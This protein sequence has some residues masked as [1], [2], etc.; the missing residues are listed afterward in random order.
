VRV[1]DLGGEQRSL[2]ELTHP[3]GVSSLAWHPDG[4][5]LATACDDLLIRLWDVATGKV[6]PLE[7]HRNRGIEMAFNPAGDCL[8]SNDWSNML[9]LWDPRTGRQLLQAPSTASVFSRDGSLL[10]ADGS[11]TQV[12]LVRVATHGPLRCLAASRAAVRWNLVGARASPDGRL[13]L[14]SWGDKMVFVD[15][16]S[17]TEM[18]SIDIPLTTALRFDPVG[19][20]LLTTSLLTRER[21]GLLRWP[22]RAEPGA[23]R[24]HVGPPQLLDESV[25][26]LQATGCNADGHVV[27]IPRNNA[28][29]LVLHRPE[30]RRVMLGP[31]EDVRYCAVSPDGV[32]V[33]TGNHWSNQGVGATVW[34]SRSGQVVRDFAVDGACAVGFSPD[35]RWLLTN[36]GGYRLWRVETWEEGP[37]VAP[38]G[39]SGGF[40]FSPD[41]RVLALEAGFSQVRLVAVDSGA[42][43][44][45]LTVPEQTRVG[46]TCFSL[47]GTQ[48]V[49]IGSETRLLY[50]WD[51]RA[52]RAELRELRLDWEW[53]DFPP[54]PP[55]ARGPL[56][57]DVDG[58]SL[59]PQKAP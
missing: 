7:G 20:E 35:G 1:V 23:V 50:I 53:P 40:A 38:P 27:A 58:G 12:R 41:G 3:Y 31:R 28:P 47:D 14:V 32:L 4:Q 16:A 25:N 57:V 5:T 48:L 19:G 45:R 46:P 11:G 13:V 37:R 18:G 42:E 49:A 34:D 2:A 43:I 26:P 55:A 59:F 52:L 8:L 15:W 24:L 6:V 54:A 17:G 30:N 44:A 36:G 39:E 51:L 21:G 9:R 29:T 10:A 33:A 56:R 22:V